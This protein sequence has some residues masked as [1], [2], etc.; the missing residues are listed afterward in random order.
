[1]KPTT[2]VGKTICN[3][4]K[5]IC[6]SQRAVKCSSCS[7]WQHCRCTKL[8]KMQIS[9]YLNSNQSFCS[10]CSNDILPFQQVCDAEFREMFYNHFDMNTFK[11]ITSSLNDAPN[12]D[13]LIKTNC[14]YQNIQCYK[15]CLSNSKNKMICP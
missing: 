8:T 13:D 11:Q 15:K 7:E 5:K 2:D 12:I 14:K 10:V 1:M 9:L 3:I 6:G 4:F